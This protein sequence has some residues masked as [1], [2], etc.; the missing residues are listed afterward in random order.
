MLRPDPY[1]FFFFQSCNIFPAFCLKKKRSVLRQLGISLC[2]IPEIPGRKH[3]E[4]M[5][6]GKWGTGRE[7]GDVRAEIS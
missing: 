7:M 3:K 1:V 6:D 4:E 5:G 2:A